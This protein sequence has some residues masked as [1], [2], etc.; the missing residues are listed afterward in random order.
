MSQEIT[1]AMVKQFSSNVFHLSQQKGSKLQPF[2]R[3]EV[4][5]AEAAFYERIGSVS[6]VR[7]SSR[8]SD[9]PQMDTPHS[10]RR[11]TIYDY[12]WA[13]LVDKED[14]IRLLISPE[15]QYAQAAMWALGR[16]KDD[17]IIEE[18]LGNAYSGKDG[19]TA[20]AL[21]NS[22]K[23]VATDGADADGTNLNTLTLRLLKKKFDSNEVDESIP[24]HLAV[25]SSQIYSLLGENQIT[26]SDYNSI[27]A[28][29]QGEVNSFMGFQFHRLER[30]GTTTATTTFTLAD[31]T[32]GAGAQTLAVGARRC[33][34][35]AQDG[36][37]LAT[38]AEVKG[39][40]S[41]RADKSYATQVYASMSIGGTRME[42]VKVVE[43]LCDE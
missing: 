26:S 12:E 18:A 32:V 2:V 25:T 13:D 5:N 3:N 41:E 27:K 11:V 6:A 38:G 15:S 7:K 21:G 4:Q 35:W 42:E 9:T 28:L 30:L 31:G 43:V 19:G 34:A 22:Q 8:H 23:L 14:K 20:V 39:R 40:V 37:L 1:T 24:R 17:V 10:R 29:V 33:I 36:I 16:A